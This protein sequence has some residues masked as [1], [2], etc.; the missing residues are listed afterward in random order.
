MRLLKWQF[1]P[2]KRARSWRATINDQR[3]E[4]EQLLH[5]DPS[6]RR[7]VDALIRMRYRTAR[8]NAAG[9]IGLALRA[10]PSRY[11]YPAEQVLDSTYFPEATE[12]E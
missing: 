8:A 2:Q 4:I 11:P 6:L 5:D 1:Q 3:D 12:D 10:F 9:E 7:E